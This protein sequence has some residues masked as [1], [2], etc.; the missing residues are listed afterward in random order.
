M[1]GKLIKYEYKAT[2]RTFIPLYI[3][4]L[5][6]AI[7]NRL[8]DERNVEIG[9]GI[10]ACILVGLFIALVVIT[11]MVIIQRFNKNL[12]GDE[13]YLMLTL[14]VKSGYLITS[15]TFISIVW[16]IISGIVACITCFILIGTREMLNSL[17][18]NFGEI[19][20]KIDW[21]ITVD[22]EQV[23]VIFF[24]IAMLVLTALTYIGFIFQIYLAL[25][26]GQLPKLAKYRSIVAFGAFCVISVVISIIINAMVDIENRFI[27]N[28]FIANSFVIESIY[29]DTCL[30]IICIILFQSI[31][32]ILDKH[33]N[34]D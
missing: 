26:I 16:T 22:N 27:V 17:L 18:T 13:G 20:S 8:F 31:K 25:A 1:L 3:A 32:S 5:L 21:Q 14:P 23:N 7:V 33:L 6:V 9:F 2:M 10:S 29:E 34:L 12:L 4:I 28:R 11:L 15:K 19:W 30:L 24:L